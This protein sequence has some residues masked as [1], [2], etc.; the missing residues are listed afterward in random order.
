MDPNDREVL[1]VRHFEEPSSAD[2]IGPIADEFVAAFRHGQAP[3]VEEFARRYPAH[4]DKI[5]EI[6]P[7]LLLME[8]AKCSDAT[9]GPQR[10]AE[11]ASLAQLGDYQILR[12]LGRG[13]MGVVYE[14]RQISLGRHVA[15]K[16]LPPHALLD[17]RQLA[18]FQREARSAAKLHHT[19]I[20]PVFGVGEQDGL[21]YYVM[22]FIAGMGLDTVLDELRH[23]RHSGG[24]QATTRGRAP[25]R[26]TD[27]MPEVTTVDMARSLLMGEFRRPRPAAA[28][29]PT[30]GELAVET[31]PGAPAPAVAADTAGT[32]RL[33]GHSEASSPGESGNQYWQ[34]VAR[35]GI[36]VADALAHAASQGVLHRDIKPSNLLLDGTGNVWVTDFG[37]AKADSDTD[38]LTHTGDIVG[39]LRYLAP[40]RFNGQG[41]LRSDVY[42]LGLTLYELLVLRPAFDEADRNKLLN[43]VMHDEPVRPRKLNPGVPRDLETVVLKAIARDP[44][45]RYQTAGALAEDLQRF[46]DGRPIT[47]RPV[48]HLERAVK[49]VKR[50]PVV[51]G[52][53]LA[54]MLALAVGT[55]VSYLK[56]L[57][58]QQH[59]GIAEDREKEARQETDKAKK[60]RDFL[61]SILALS[62]AGG[63]RGT[64]TARQILDDAEQRIPKEFADQ[65]ELRAELLAAI[66]TVYAKITAR[67]PLAMILQVSGTVQLQSA[68]NPNQRAVP[69]ALLYKGDV[70]TLAADAQ[71]QLVSLSDLH[72]ERLKPGTKATVHRKG[73]EPADAIAER[74]G[75]VLMSFVRLPKGT[76]Y[77]GWDGK[78]KAR[79]REIKEDFEIAVH[80]V[81]QGQWQAIMGDNPS[82]FSRFGSDRNEVKDIS[83]EELKLFPVERVSWDDVQEFLKKLNDRERGRGFWYRLPTEA[84]W[85]YACRGGATSLEECSYPFYLDRPTNELSSEQANIN[86]DGPAGKAPKGK[87]LGRPTRVGAYPP[88]KLGLCD[89]HGNM[90]QWCADVGGSA[91]VCRGGSWIRHGVSCQAASRL[92]IAA[93]NRVNNV[94]FRLARVP[95][96]K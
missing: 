27:D 94:G 35:V 69:Q 4:A 74:T 68:R 25:D 65:P 57:D 22:Q 2:P 90:G 11:A 72:Q 33:P 50:N 24:Q 37:L 83:D 82:S 39:T 63:H 60:A 66:E 64:M 48:G 86:G 6:L 71:V 49:W 61:V 41:D 56:Y 15:I 45:H 47:A 80:D 77:M 92:T 21:H 96:A 76:F 53:A 10:P 5:R 93:T 32:I 84:E 12:E 9:P 91:R 58:A 43:Q 81:T 38:N 42:S 59:K 62:D 23:L 3:S 87:Y 75:D 30:S 26:P 16:V 79:P 52:A 67:A 8:Q 34:S 85:E 51:T 95:C 31:D 17:P 36:Q 55:T 70:L 18:R 40:E 7:T 78:N 28:Q 29:A 46:L 13:G 89:M 14:A 73:C 44:A 19:N 88:N 20:V 1:I 54:V